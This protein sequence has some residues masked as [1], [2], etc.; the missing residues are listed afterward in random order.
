MPYFKKG[1]HVFLGGA[2]SSLTSGYYCTGYHLF[3]LSFHSL[4]LSLFS[5]YSELEI[6]FFF[7]SFVTVSK[8]GLK[9]EDKVRK[10]L[11]SLK[12]NSFMWYHL[13]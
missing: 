9:F 5:F 8:S 1:K 2:I 13:N 12:K 3:D 11:M 6:L 10:G 7:L 4:L